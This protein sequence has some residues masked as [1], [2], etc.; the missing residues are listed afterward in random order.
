LEKYQEEQV[1]EKTITPT[2]IAYR[3]VIIVIRVRIN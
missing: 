3:R 2:I 1:G